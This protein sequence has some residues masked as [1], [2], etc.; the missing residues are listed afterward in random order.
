MNLTFNKF[1]FIEEASLEDVIKM[2]SIPH[3][4]KMTPEQIISFLER[5]DLP[6][7]I[8]EKVDGYNVSFGLMGDNEVYVKTKTQQPQTD[9][10]YFE[11]LAKVYPQNIVFAKLLNYLNNNNFKEWYQNTFTNNYTFF[12][13]KLP[14]VTGFQIFAELFS[15][16][17][18]SNVIQYSEEN[19]GKGALYVFFIRLNAPMLKEG[20][21]ITDSDIG[22]TIV[23]DFVNNFNSKDGWMVYKKNLLDVN[24]DVDDQKKRILTFISSNMEILKARKRDS[25]TLRLKNEAKQQLEEMMNVFERSILSQFKQ[26]PSSLGGGGMEGIIVKNL[27]NGSIAKIVDPEFAERRESMYAGSDALKNQK[28]ILK[29]Q[30]EEVLNYADS[31][32]ALKRAGKVAETQKQ[33]KSIE[34]VIMVL[35]GDAFKENPALKKA[36]EGH[37]FDNTYIKVTKILQDHLKACENVVKEIDPNNVDAIKKAQISLDAEKERIMDFFNIF[38]RAYELKN[39]NQF[40]VELAK[41]FIGHKGI[42][43]LKK[44]VINK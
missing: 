13:K 21:D 9:P 38:K 26:M 2:P 3:L 18:K 33:F 22:R 28:K 11:D 40:Y 12:S 16:D 7:D 32:S 37:N 15:G 34:D 8:S 31:F 25:E 42:E 29:K 6:F 44:F 20:I 5:G 24:M 36:F 35:F 23:S 4:S 41:L 39:S 14:E 30:I 43:D 17:E 10:S 19:I 27:K 1:Y